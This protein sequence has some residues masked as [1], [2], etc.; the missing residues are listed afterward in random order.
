MEYRTLGRTGLQVSVIGIG[1]WQLSGPLTL[2]SKADGFPDPGRDKVINLI[3]ACGD[4]GINFIDAA[5]LY[6]EGEGERRIGEAILG[7]RDR[8]ILSTKFGLRRGKNGERIVNAKPDTIRQSIENSLQQLRTDYID[9]YLYHSPPD[10]HLIDE[11]QEVLNTLRQEG[12]LR[13]Y[14]ISTDDC[15]VLSQM[16]DR[17]AVDVAMFDQSLLSHPTPMLKLVKEHQLGL[18][19][20][21]ALAAGLLSGKYFRQ[22][23][24]LSEQD[25]RKEVPYPWQKYAFY[26]RFL[27]EGVSMTAFA[28]RYLLD[29][30]TTHTIVLGGKSIE[31]YREALNILTLPELDLKTHRS[32]KRARETMRAR[33]FSVR[34]MRRLGRPIAQLVNRGLSRST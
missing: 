18:I 28:L 24:R 10:R 9:I 8:W 21:G 7:K 6:G 31:N 5:E 26:E 16:L 1:S 27:P 13:F 29:F 15:Q 3:Q 4:L 23:P 22:A 14:G 25:I 33:D 19:V 30:D 12:K 11:G 20:R 34:V 17:K 2:D 32:L